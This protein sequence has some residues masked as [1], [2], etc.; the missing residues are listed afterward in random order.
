M[1]TPCTHYAPRPGM[2]DDAVIARQ[3]AWGNWQPRPAS[4]ADALKRSTTIWGN[5]RQSG[6]P[7][8]LVSLVGE[9]GEPDFGTVPVRHVPALM[10]RLHELIEADRR[11]L[12][13]QRAIIAGVA[14]QPSARSAAEPAIGD[15]LAGLMALWEAHRKPAARSRIEARTAVGRFE[16]VVGRLP[17]RAITDEHARR[18]KADLLA[19]YG[20]KNA[21]RQKLWG[22]LRAT[23]EHGDG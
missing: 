12:E 21:T 17:Y 5:L 1:M 9:D 13:A 19:D 10:E 2:V 7:R 15:T 18:F 16:R 6:K 11:T 23:A 22:M 3:I 8:A 14:E 20:L 4:R